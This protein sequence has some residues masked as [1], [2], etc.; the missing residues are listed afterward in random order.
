M[1]RLLR[2]KK[3]LVHCAL[4]ATRRIVV[5]RTVRSKPMWKCNCATQ[6]S[7]PT[8][9]RANVCSLSLG[10]MCVP[11]ATPSVILTSSVS[12]RIHSYANR[13]LCRRSLQPAFREN[14]S[15]RPR[16]SKKL[17]LVQVVEECAPTNPNPLHPRPKANHQR[18]AQRNCL[19]QRLSHLPAIEFEEMH[20]NPFSA[21][22]NLHPEGYGLP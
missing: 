22:S 2:R 14:L 9:C 8:T 1:T 11:L 18:K 3:S 21:A 19:S 4:S 6:S 20:S 7:P 15:M 10:T 16:I 17:P 5:P 13:F 12:P